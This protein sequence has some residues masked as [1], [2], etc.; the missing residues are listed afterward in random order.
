MK[1]AKIYRERE[2]PPLRLES[3]QN[4]FHSEVDRYNMSERVSKS[5]GIAGQGIPRLGTCSAAT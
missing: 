1:W 2:H 3:Y 4:K 5:T